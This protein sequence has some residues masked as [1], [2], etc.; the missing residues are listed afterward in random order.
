M[1]DALEVEQ[2]SEAAAK[3]GIRRSRR[4]G[5][6]AGA[7]ENAGRFLKTQ[8]CSVNPAHKP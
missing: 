4:R 1:W 6:E 8:S 7:R 3:R 2:N 5:L